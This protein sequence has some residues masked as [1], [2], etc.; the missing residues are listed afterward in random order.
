[1]VLHKTP[2]KRFKATLI[3]AALLAAPGLALAETPLALDA[4]Q[5]WRLSCDL[6]ALVREDG[7]CRGCGRDV[8]GFEWLPKTQEAR[9]SAVDVPSITL[10]PLT[11]PTV[12][13]GRN[14]HFLMTEEQ[15]GAGEVYNGAGPVIVSLDQQTGI[16][17]MTNH[18]QEDRLRA[19]SYEGPC[20]P[21]D[22]P[23]AAEGQP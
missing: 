2:A 3:S 22:K 5:G 1:M 23:A 8:F 6:M 10:R 18:N 14:L 21:A 13:N 9:L 20:V 7:W 15:T 11:G 4:T 12:D 17:V 19:F 16:M